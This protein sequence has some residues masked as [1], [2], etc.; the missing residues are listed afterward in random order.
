MQTTKNDRS[1]LGG[2]SD[3]AENTMTAK[4]KYQKKITCPEVCGGLPNQFCPLS[5]FLIFMN[6]PV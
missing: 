5:A 6:I 3:T 2:T 4:I 1:D